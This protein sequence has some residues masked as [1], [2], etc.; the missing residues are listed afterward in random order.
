MGRPGL[1]HV[2]I[3]MPPG[4]EPAARQFYGGLLGLEEIPKPEHLQGRG[5]VW[6]RTAT[7]D[8]HLGV[9]HSFMAATKAHVASA[10]SSLHEVRETLVRAGNDIVDDEPLPGFDRFYTVDPFGNRI[11]LMSPVTG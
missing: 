9:D 11:E 3:A 6:F 2:Q 1:H 5:G 4:G 10:C 8:L 7:L